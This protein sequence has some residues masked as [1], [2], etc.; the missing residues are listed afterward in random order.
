MQYAGFIFDL[1]GTL[2][3]TLDDL[4][5]TGNMVLSEFGFPTHETEAYRYLVG[6]GLRVLFEKATPDNTSDKDI[7]RCCLMFGQV[8]EKTW[9]RVTKPYQGINKMLCQLK[10]KNIK[11][12]V[13]SNKPDRF[14][15]TYI[16]H[17][18]SDD[19]FNFGFGQR[20]N[21]PKKPDPAG[22]F[23]IAELMKLTREQLVYVG[24]SSVD[25]Q[26]GKNSGVFTV[27]V[28]WG[29]RSVEE[30]QQNG[31]DIIIEDPM[32]LLQYAGSY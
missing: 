24:D 32:E 18:W 23:E 2:L 3:D 20:E 29:F 17:F 15:Q 19:I 9:N 1:D 16:S 22:I 4:A 13:L 31:A 7:I 10:E 5:Y 25:M 11:L 8:Y 30:L 12:A 6:N 21:I 14:T 28:S 27:G 26:T